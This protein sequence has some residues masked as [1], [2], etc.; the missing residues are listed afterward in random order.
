ME[1][2]LVGGNNAKKK[3][4]PGNAITPLIGGEYLSVESD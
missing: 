1:Y 4:Q 2:N 3:L